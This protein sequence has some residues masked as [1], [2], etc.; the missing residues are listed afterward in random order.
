MRA[1]VVGSGP[2]GMTAALLLARRGHEV[3]IIDRDPGPV[4]GVEWDRAGVMQLHLPHGF[5]PQVRHLLGE[6]LPDVYDAMLAAAGELLVPEGFPDV[7]AFLQIR[8]SL[9]DRV[10][11]EIVSAEPGVTR[12]TGHADE[13]VVRDGRATGVLVDG[14]LVE[15][16][17][18]LDAGGRM[19]RTSAAHRDEGS[20]VSC[21]M[22]YASRSYRLLPGADVGPVNGG[23]GY[24]NEH[25]GFLS[26]V[27]R[28]DAGTF[29]V[30]I[31]RRSDD[32]ELAVLRENRVFEAA[33]R[34]LPGIAEWT[35]PGRSE[36]TDD[37]RAGAGLSN[38]YRGQATEVT[39][40]LA[41]GDAFAITNPQ[42]A[43]GVVL[44]MQSAAFV[45]D[46][47]DSA[48]RD[49]WAEALDAWGLEQ[50]HP[51]V[52]DHVAW[53]DSLLRRWAGLPI[54]ADG[55][56]GLDVLGAAAL[57]RPHFMA[58]LGPF[59]GMFV[60]PDALEPLRD[61]VREMVRAGWQPPSPGGVTRDDLVAVV[62]DAALVL[63]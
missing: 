62:R 47:V 22:A 39:G 42:G 13:V 44:G 50:L 37:V 54:E 51:W 32:D 46:L 21:R 45:A 8:R 55:S 1:A 5:R 59:F 14:R 11:W 52:E 33:C 24:I 57:E 63:A 19:G 18:V 31:V 25:D 15:A 48:P 26:F 12:V 9:F 6:R 43:R 60:G 34:V 3:T 35:D 4:P 20:R 40:L 17:V 53:D 28:H 7:A 10:F 30:L 29:K 56:I 38:S 16:D 61:E 58:T 49:T 41:I 36:P 2:S 23:P 27:F